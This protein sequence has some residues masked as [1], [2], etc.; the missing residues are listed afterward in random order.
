CATAAPP[1][2]V[3]VPR[4][5]ARYSWAA[6]ERARS[7]G[8]IVA[9]F[10]DGSLAKEEARSQNAPASQRSNKSW[11]SIVRA[12]WRAS[13]KG[14]RLGARVG[15]FVDLDFVYSPRWGLYDQQYC[16]SKT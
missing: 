8:R 16:P 10:M 13:V 3:T 2:S 1:G 12:H 6:A 15:V 11:A 7:R 9:R 14:V 5:E 4:T